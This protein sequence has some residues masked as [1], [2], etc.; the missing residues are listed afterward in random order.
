M[1]TIKTTILAAALALSPIAASAAPAI[2]GNDWASYCSAPM[3]T[4]RWGYCFGYTRGVGDGFNIWRTL[5]PDTAL[6]CIPATVQAEQLVD[7]AKEYIKRNP[8]DRH[9]DAVELL[10]LAFKEAWPC[11]DQPRTSFRD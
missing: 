3:G 11:K 1:N 8:R 4:Q 6:I 10:G 7:V 5:R 9:D 2:S